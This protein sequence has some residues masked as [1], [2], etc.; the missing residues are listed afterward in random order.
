MK[1]VSNRIR[2]LA[3]E[4]SW[5]LKKIEQARK[6]AAQIH[7]IQLNSEDKYKRRLEIEQQREDEIEHWHTEVQRRWDKEAMFKGQWKWHLWMI[8]A[9]LAEEER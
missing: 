6:R 2:L 7:Q 5:V 3:T 1:L 4:E 8:N 9:T